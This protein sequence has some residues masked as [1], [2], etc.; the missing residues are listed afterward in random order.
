MPDQTP[1]PSRGVMSHFPSYHPR[2]PTGWV[3]DPNGPFAWRGRYHLF[4]QHNPIGPVHRAICWG[5][6]SSNDL[7]RWRVEP[8][9]LQ[10]TPDSPDAEGC[11]SGCVVDDAGVP[12]AVYTASAGG[13]AGQTICLAYADDGALNRWEKV[14]EPVAAAPANMDLLGFRDPFVFTHGSSRY[15][16]VGAGQAPY[17]R[18]L[19]LLYR[20]DELTR[21]TYAGVLLDSDDPVAGDVAPADFWECPQLIQL[22]GRW[23]LI[24]SILVE[25]DPGRVAYLVGDL[26]A[27]DGNLRFVA[28][29]GGLVDHGHDFYAPA[30]LTIGHQV[31]LWGWS[32]EDRPHS[33][34]LAAG[35]AGSLTM[36]REISLSPDGALR[37]WPLTSF[38]GEEGASSH[39]TLLGP[40]DSI[41]LGDALDLDIKVIAN[42]E[43]RV[44]LGLDDLLRLELDLIEGTVELHRRVHDVSRRG[45]DTRGILAPGLLRARMR[46]IID[47]SMVEIFVADGPSF[48]ERVYASRPRSLTMSAGAEARCEVSV[49]PLGG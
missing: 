38:A 31:V 45:W 16:V 23:V 13:D 12:V 19:L 35:W 5:H 21:W 6:L 26:V 46:I 37:V 4:F 24:V 25:P 33:E 32:W 30:V 9:A 40:S 2:P 28:G 18:P 42:D 39:V 41:P 7:V 43:G 10:P 1:S 49:R 48:T 20:C 3:N 22:G 29:S 27:D 36:A 15:A 34:V 17:G 8:V 14:S 11:W 47:G 44:T